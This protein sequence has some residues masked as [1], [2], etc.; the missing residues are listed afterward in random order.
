MK[1]DAGER[2]RVDSDN[3]G[4]PAEAASR[5]SSRPTTTRSFLEAALRS[6]LAQSVPADEIIVVDDGSTDHPE[7][8]DGAV[9]RRPVDPAAE[10]RAVSRAQ[11]RMAG[12]HDRVRRLPRRRRPA[13][14]GLRSPHNLQRLSADPRGRLLLR[15]LRGRRRAEPGGEYPQSSSPL[16]DGYPS[17]LRRNLI[18]MHAAVMYR[19]RR[20]SP[21]IGGFEGG[22]RRLRGLRRLSPDGVCASRSSFGPEPAGR[23]LAPSKATCR[24]TR[25]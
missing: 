23:V 17:L 22:A 20:A 5:S 19:T 10:C 11:H 12:C 15:R 1:H 18:G 14:A 16:T 24:A 8:R 21:Q 7:T 3:D 4:C 25:R 6:A 2:R 13:A 9:P